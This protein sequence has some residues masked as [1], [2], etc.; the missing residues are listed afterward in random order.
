[1]WKKIVGVFVCFLF[2]FSALPAIT[3]TGA[4]KIDNEPL[5]EIKDFSNNLLPDRY[6][7]GICVGTFVYNGIEYDGGFWW[8]NVTPINLRF[9]ALIY[10][11]E[12]YYFLNEPITENPAYINKD[13]FK[14][15]FVGI[16]FMF[17]WGGSTF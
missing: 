9:F 10:V 5:S 7:F 11:I 15:G 3:I 6:L 14:H 13:V 1:M 8:Y 2:L 16:H 4:I 17:I 12:N